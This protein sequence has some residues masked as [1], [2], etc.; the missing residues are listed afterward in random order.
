MLEP[1]DILDEKN[2]ILRKKSKEVDF[3]LSNKEKKLI[4]DM[5]KYLRKSQDEKRA[6]REGLRPGMG[7]SAV[8]L[9]LLKRFFVVSLKREYEDGSEE[10]EEY[11]VV[12]PTLISHSEEEIYVEEG[13]GCLSVNRD[14]KGIIPRY[15]RV[16]I[17]AYDIDGNEVEIRGREEIS[18]VFQHEIDHLN[19][20]LFPDRIDKKNPFKNM[21]KMRSL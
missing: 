8:Q 4:K 6:E 18:V 1:K 14:V 21:D 20:I 9:G 16:K 19:G 10:F 17:H 2:K 11:V 3:P 13:E 5:I 15:A 12:N 7:L